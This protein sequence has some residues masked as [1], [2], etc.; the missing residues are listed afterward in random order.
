M[1][2]CETY[3]ALVRK[4]LLSGNFGKKVYRIYLAMLSIAIKKKKKKKKDH[5]TLAM[6]RYYVFSRELTL[7]PLFWKFSNSFLSIF[8]D[9]S[10]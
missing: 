7:P 1:R 4:K 8:A 5:T 3:I 6:K 9:Y 10:T 2:S